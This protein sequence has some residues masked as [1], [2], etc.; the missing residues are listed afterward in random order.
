[1]REQKSKKI[2]NTKKSKKVL[3]TLKKLKINNKKKYQ[4]NSETVQKSE[5]NKKVGKYYKKCYFLS[6][7]ISGVHDLT[8]ALEFSPFKNPG[9]YPKRYRRTENGAGKSLC[10]ILDINISQLP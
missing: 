10:Q 7:S 2:S 9:C 3:R 4:K 5:K 6:F 1:M 8:R